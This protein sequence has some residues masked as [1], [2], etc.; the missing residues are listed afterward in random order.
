MKPRVC[1]LVPSSFSSARSRS[2][3]RRKPQGRAVGPES[4]ILNLVALV[5]IGLG[6][7]VVPAA[8][9]FGD[10]D[11]LDWDDPPRVLT[12]ARLS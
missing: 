4:L 12:P 6:S 3:S 5:G 8:H 10:R 7:G 2:T 11:H 9:A 1:V